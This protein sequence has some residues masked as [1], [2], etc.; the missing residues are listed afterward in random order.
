MATCESVFGSNTFAAIA[1]SFCWVSN[2]ELIKLID[3]VDSKI[4]RFK[5]Q[6]FQDNRPKTYNVSELP[7]NLFS[8]TSSES[9]DSVTSDPATQ[10]RVKQDQPGIDTNWS[11]SCFNWILLD[12]VY[13]ALHEFAG[14]DSVV[15]VMCE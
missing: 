8:D 11:D 5:P 15:K 2:L 3:S 10:P 1:V 14:K 13:K 9:G 12:L 4:R 6:V 7:P